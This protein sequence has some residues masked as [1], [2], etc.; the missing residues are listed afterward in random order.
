MALWAR[1]AP[2][3]KRKGDLMVKSIRER[4]TVRSM[5][6]E[7]VQLKTEVTS[8][9]AQS[10]GADS[11]G[12]PIPSAKRIPVVKRCVPD[13]MKLVPVHGDGA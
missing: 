12:R 13:G 2:P 3:P 7:D 4:N 6:A 5:H 9:P 1:I 10:E 11:S 8:V